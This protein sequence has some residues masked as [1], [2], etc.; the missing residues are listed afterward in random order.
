MWK[1]EFENPAAQAESE[2]LISGGKLSE[3]DRRV[4]TTWIR[5][6]TFHGPESIQRDGKWA[7]HEL[8]DDWA[9]YRSSS[10]SNTG[11]IIYKIEKDVVKVKIARIT[12]E[13]D[14]E[15]KK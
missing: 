15:R 5:Q 4:I 1:V 14:Y 8:V 13:H 7:D 12:T 11:R 2:K 3:D 9:G 10:F 6:V